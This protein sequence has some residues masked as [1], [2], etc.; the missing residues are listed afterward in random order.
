M[1]LVSEVITKEKLDFVHLAWSLDSTY[2]LSIT[3][4]VSDQLSCVA[5][6]KYL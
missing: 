1:S 4:G 5:Q 2:L 6:F 3:T